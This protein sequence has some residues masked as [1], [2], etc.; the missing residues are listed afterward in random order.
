MKILKKEFDVKI[1]IIIRLSIICLV[2]IL[3]VDYGY[4]IKL[5]LTK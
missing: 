5:L 2:W 4:T 3:S 1:V